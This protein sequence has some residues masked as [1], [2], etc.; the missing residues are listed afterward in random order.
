MWPHLNQSL[1]CRTFYVLH[2]LLK[3]RQISPII[4]KLKYGLHGAEKLVTLY[5]INSGPIFMSGGS[6]SLRSSLTCFIRTKTTVEPS[7]T[8][9][10][11]FIQSDQLGR[12]E[13]TNGA[14]PERAH[15]W[16]WTDGRGRLHPH[17]WDRRQL[18]TCSLKRSP[19]IWNMSLKRPCLRNTDAHVPE[20]RARTDVVPL[21]SQTPLLQGGCRGARVHPRYS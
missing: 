11:T 10:A 1:I 17:R 12:Y 18:D 9:C 5:A 2:T 21:M 14:T 16:N 13:W 15:R 4:F 3:E 6:A 8:E 19:H 20:W 7:A